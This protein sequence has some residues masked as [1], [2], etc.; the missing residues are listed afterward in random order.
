MAAATEPAPPSSRGAAAI[1]RAG[2]GGGSSANLTLPDGQGQGGQADAHRNN[3]SKL[4]VSL[5]QAT[6]LK[7]KLP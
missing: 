6:Q 2:H 4:R 5:P 1:R 3:R 7:P